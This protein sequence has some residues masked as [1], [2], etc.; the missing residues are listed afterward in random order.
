MV[1]AADFIDSQS[2][3]S[4]MRYYISLEI[5]EGTWQRPKA[6]KNVAR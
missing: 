3:F 5:P 6:Q 2:Q 4:D 1:L